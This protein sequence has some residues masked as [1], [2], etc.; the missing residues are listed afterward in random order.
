VFTVS[1]SV[2]VSVGAAMQAYAGNDTIAVKGIP[3]QLYGSG[4]TNY[5]WTSPTALIQTPFIK[6]AK[7]ILNNDAVFYLKVSD[8][9]GC[10]GF[11]TVF[12]KVYE[13]P[14]YYIPNAFTPNGD[15]VNDIFRAIP[16]GI[17]NTTYFRI[18]NRFGELVF[19]TNQWLKGW[20]GKYKGKDQANGTYVWI[21]TGTDRNFNKVSEQGTVNLIR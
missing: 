8:G 15:G 12:V 3:H 20:D 7:A 17:A 14:K 9:I 10:E 2:R 5:T 18:F 13:G 16:V 4:G 21:V 11:D 1:D 19:E 6:N